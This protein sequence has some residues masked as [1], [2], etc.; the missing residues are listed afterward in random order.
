MTFTIGTTFDRA[1]QWDKRLGQEI[2]FLRAWLRSWN[3]R[4]VLDLACGSGRHSVAL[5]HHGFT[6]TG[7]DASRAMLEDAR[8]LALVESATC[9]FLSGDM[10]TPPP[11]TPQN[12]VLCLGNS[13]CLL[14]H[15]EAVRD[16][17]HAMHAL[18]APGGGLILHILNYARFALP[19]HAFFPL[20]TDL[21][22]GLPQRHFLK[23]IDVK[24]DVAWVHLAC[25]EEDAPGQWSR[26]VKSDRL[27]VLSAPQL[28]QEVTG[29]GFGEVQ[30][31]GSMLGGV[32]HAL[33]HDV[34]LCAR[35][36]K[37]ALLPGRLEC[38]GKPS[39][40]ASPSREGELN[41]ISGS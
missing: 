25:I 41:R 20:K 36:N 35:K 5:A 6:M 32:Y 30:V 2:P 11:L 38:D 31:Y 3:A 28:L 14:P 8:Q 7:V 22:D 10:R 16:S 18:L 13:L 23:M 29:A 40:T 37:T 26:S 21:H 33:S 19:E 34:V 12:A 4:H 24:G 15:R 9:H 39:G 17:L 1:T 27:T